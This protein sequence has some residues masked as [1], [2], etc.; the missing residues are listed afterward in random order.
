MII[1]G[2]GFAWVQWSEKDWDASG[3]QEQPV[4][5]SQLYHGD[6]NDDD[7]D[8]DDA[9]DYDNDDDYDNY[10]DAVFRGHATSR[11]KFINISW[12]K[13]NFCFWLKIPNLSCPVILRWKIF[14]QQKKMF[15]SY[16]SSS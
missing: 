8:D 9:D 5:L 10:D 6:N 3:F 2:I 1:S 11:Y 15:L 4:K 13:V 12:L 14:V 16:S 7:N